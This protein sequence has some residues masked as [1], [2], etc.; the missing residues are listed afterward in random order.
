M[1]D[2]VDSKSIAI[3]RGGSIPLQGNKLELK[4]WIFIDMSYQNRIWGTQTFFLPKLVWGLVGFKNGIFFPNAVWEQDIFF[5][6]TGFFH[7]FY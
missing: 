4:K 6:Q 5:P 1:V 7:K 3:W 2:T